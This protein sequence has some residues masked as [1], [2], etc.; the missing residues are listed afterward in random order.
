MIK[1]NGKLFT[2]HVQLGGEGGREKA[3][4]HFRLWDGA[5]LSVCR[6]GLRAV[7]SS[8]V[9]SAWKK[10]KLFPGKSVRSRYAV[11]DR[12]SDRDDVNRGG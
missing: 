1:Y 11:R 8:C 6:Q 2:R 12:E 4:K 9:S 3:G 10:R 7:G 5:V